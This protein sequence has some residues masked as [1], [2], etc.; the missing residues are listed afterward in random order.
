MKRPRA[1]LI[2]VYNAD[3]GLFN[4]LGDIGHKIFSPETYECNLCALTHGNFG[5]K[6]EWRDYL[7]TL[8]AD[9][10]FLH[11]DQFRSKFKTQASEKLPAIWRIE[12]DEPRLLINSNAINDCRSL[13]DLKNLVNDRLSH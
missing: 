12:N 2:F 10:D 7:K 3:S 9:F 13:D 1:R 8:E 6:R 5:M 4:L 11:A